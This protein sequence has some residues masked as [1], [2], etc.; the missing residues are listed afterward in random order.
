MKSLN[1]V[2]IKDKSPLVK[3]Y[4]LNDMSLLEQTPPSEELISA[5][6]SASPQVIELFEQVM[7]RH[8]ED[9]RLT[10]GI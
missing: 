2:Q 9:L 10:P 4:V 3:I 1:F 6:R 8:N 7:S 5:I